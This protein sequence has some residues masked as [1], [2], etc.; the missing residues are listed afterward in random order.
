M[1]V[2]AHRGQPSW[3]TSLADITMRP[4]PSVMWASMLPDGA[5]LASAE[6]GCDPLSPAAPPL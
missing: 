5:V 4:V 3:M 1:T 2:A 6:A